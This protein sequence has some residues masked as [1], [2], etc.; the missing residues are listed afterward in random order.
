ML[1]F[2]WWGK[3]SRHEVGGSSL[4]EVAPLLMAAHRERC[5]A[6]NPIL[7]AVLLLGH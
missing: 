7:A 1:P 5:W 4:W 6:E 3:H 2:I